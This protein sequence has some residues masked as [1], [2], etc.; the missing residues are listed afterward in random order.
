MLLVGAGTLVLAVLTALAG[1][2]YAE[3][4]AAALLANIGAITS[5]GLPISAVVGSTCAVLTL[6][7]SILAGWLI[8]RGDKKADGGRSWPDAARHRTLA[9]TVGL[10]V[11]WT[12]AAIAQLLLS[13]SLSS[14]QAVGSGRFG[15]DI[16]VYM[17]TDLGVWM[18]WGAILAAATSAVALAGDSV[19]VARATA[20]MALVGVMARGMTGHAAGDA[21]HESATSSIFLHLIAVAAWVGPLV[22]LQVL[23]NE[24][25]DADTATFRD[26][27]HR[28]SRLA[29]AAWILLAFS[30]AIALYSRVTTIDQVL[31]HP[32]GQL[33]AIK[34]VVLLVLAAFGAMQ[35]SVIARTSRSARRAFTRLA[36]MEMVLMG[37]AIGPGA[38]MSSSPPPTENIPPPPSPAG[39]LTNYPLPPNPMGPAVFTQWRLDVF[40]FAVS[41]LVLW[42]AFSTGRASLSRGRSGRGGRALLIAAIAY[43][44]VTSGPIAV[45]SR[46]LFSAH[47]LLSVLAMVLVGFPLSLLVG[48]A[49]IRR[50]AAQPVWLR[51]MLGLVPAA[52]LSGGY[53]P[54]AVLRRVLES[55][56]ANV[57]FVLTCIAAGLLWGMLVR[58]SATTAWGSTG[59]EAGSLTRVIPAVVAGAGVAVFGLYLSWT[60]T[61]LAPSWFGATGRTWIAD[62]SS[63][64]HR[65]GWVL[66][67]LAAGVAAVAVGAVTRSRDPRNSRRARKNPEPPERGS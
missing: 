58:A 34:I 54:S 65:A 10:A 48:D 12:L 59:R 38:A 24:R 61:V 29:L 47:V 40:A 52:L 19:A 2:K 32:Y 28:F 15:S 8:P 56:P 36:L 27:V 23:P 63:D 21:S 31:T 51:V 18:L 64:Q 16:G 13:Y 25:D 53:L 66:V 7:G 6:G 35:R 3:G 67:V 37:S 17:V 43:V 33:G 41:A 46:I 57:G 30:G 39:I 49:R 26:T 60:A 5:V 20:I 62:A 22:L 1:A 4:T 9:I 50:L 11:V 14:G 45:Y 42:W 44:C 55:H